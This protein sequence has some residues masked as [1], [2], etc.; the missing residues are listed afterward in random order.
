VRPGPP[1]PKRT[2]TFLKSCRQAGILQL[3]EQPRPHQFHLKKSPVPSLRY[4]LLH[5]TDVCNLCC[6]HCYLGEPKKN[7][8]PLATVIKILDELEKIQGLRLVVSGGEPLMH[9]D[10]WKINQLLP[11]YNF[12]KIL[13][14][15]GLLLNKNNI[16]KL[17]FDEI[18][19]SLDGLKSGHEALRGPDTFQKT[20]KVIRLLKNLRFCVSVA[21]MVHS[22]NLSEFKNLE[23]LLQKLSVDSWTVDIPYQ[24][25]RLQHHRDLTVIPKIG[26]QFLKFGWGDQGHKVYGRFAC[27][28]HLLAVMPDGRADKCGYFLTPQSPHINNGL[29]NCFQKIKKIPLDKLA[30]RDCRFVLECRGGCRARAAG[31]FDK[32]PYLCYYN[33]R[34]E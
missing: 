16:P 17:N 22:Q 34:G 7:S 29:R 4:L 21:T 23:K 25:G 6:R 11:D 5:L 3:A 15:N 32:D 13:Q 8:L 1:V 10:F 27:G 9:R 28:T 30:C 31:P 12:R 18:Q 20:L 33:F 26:G 2:N 24:T 14:T 19:V